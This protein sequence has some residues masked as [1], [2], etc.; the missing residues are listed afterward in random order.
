MS[1]RIVIGCTLA[2]AALLPAGADA[3]Q[4]QEPPRPYVYGIYFECDVARQELADEIF[5]L[6]YLPA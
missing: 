1:R 6:A 5:E 3:Q 4:G 2:I